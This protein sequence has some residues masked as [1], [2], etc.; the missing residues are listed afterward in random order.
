MY[1]GKKNKK[2]TLKSK[3]KKKNNKRVIELRRKCTTGFTL[4]GNKCCEYGCCEDANG[5]PRCCCAGELAGNTV[6][7]GKKCCNPPRSNSSRVFNSTVKTRNY[8]SNHT[9]G[10]C[11]SSLAGTGK[12]AG[13]TVCCDKLCQKCT[14]NDKI[15]CSSP[16]TG[17]AYNEYSVSNTPICCPPDRGCCTND[18]G[19]LRCCCPGEL[20]PQPSHVWCGDR[21]CKV[22]YRL[23]VA[24]SGGCCQD[25]NGNPTCC[26]DACKKCYK[27]GKMCCTGSTV[28]RVECCDPVGRCCLDYKGWPLPCKKAGSS[29]CG[30][31][32]CDA[33]NTCCG[34]AD[35]GICCPQ[36]RE[37]CNG[38]CCPDG[39]SCQDGVCCT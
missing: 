15:C 29:C 4:C 30:R 38:E 36:G 1:K 13:K 22:E 35:S 33:G 14:D 9:G 37:C 10:C 5:D 8:T 25:A 7:C 2:T 12:N 3:F 16:T 21:C 27:K 31:N 20:D 39:Q 28:S 26:K 6:S 19:S 32:C 11:Q 24:V 17:S 23:G 34:N 18:D